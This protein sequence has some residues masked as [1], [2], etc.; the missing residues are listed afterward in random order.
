MTDL[1]HNEKYYQT[2]FFKWRQRLGFGVS[3]YACN[4][5]YLLAN[6]YLLFYY[7]NCAG[8]SAAD[9]G[10]MFVV[11][12]VIDAVT[13]YLA[14]VW[15][16][17]TNTKMGRYRPW[18]LAGAPILAIGMVLLFSVPVGWAYMAKVIWAYV[19]YIVFS[20]GY[21]VVN[22]TMTPV[23]TSLPSNSVERT[24]ITISRNIFASL[25]SLT[26][27][28]FVLPMVYFFS[29]GIKTAGS[30]LARGY[31]MSNV[32][33]GVMVIVLMCVCVFNIEEI[34]PPTVAKKKVG[35]F[36]DMKTIFKNKYYIMMI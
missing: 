13:D 26:S 16:D 2:G 9:A 30:E 28:L 22:I 11:T 1:K 29:G 20:F 10:F 33:L 32:V 14:G 17:R 27:S 18:M 24:K 8:I 25:G 19:S 15:V 12:N 23:V 31:R 21:T 36:K 6:T 7:T 3:D 4:L 5:A 34:N 35:I